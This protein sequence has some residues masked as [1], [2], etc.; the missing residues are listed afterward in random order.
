MLIH[1]SIIQITMS[2]FLFMQKPFQLVNEN[3]SDAFTDVSS[4][5]FLGVYTVAITAQLILYI[6]IIFIDER[7]LSNPV[8]LRKYGFI[9]EDIRYKSKTSKLINVFFVS[10]RM[11]VCFISLYLYNY[12]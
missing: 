9:Y 7:V 1:E 6:R 2:I 11:L 8:I 3:L 5:L 12:V 10:R 4:Y